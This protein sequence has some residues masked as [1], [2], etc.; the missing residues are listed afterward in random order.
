ML[1]QLLAKIEHG[2]Q[3]L[4]GAQVAVGSRDG[5]YPLCP[6]PDAQFTRATLRLFDRSDNRFEAPKYRSLYQV[7]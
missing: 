7:L 3:P 1:K 6:E 2:F 4:I 5:A